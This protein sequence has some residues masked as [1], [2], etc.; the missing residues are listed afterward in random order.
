MKIFS[1]FVFLTMGFLSAQSFAE[2]FEIHKTQIDS[3]VK[4]CPVEPLLIAEE[5]IQAE[6]EGLRWRK[7]KVSCF[8]KLKLRYVHA[9]KVPD[10]HA[11]AGVIKVKRGSLA[12]EA[13]KYNKDFYSY[14]V[15][16]TVED[17]NGMSHKGSFSFMTNAD[18]GGEKPEQGCALISSTPQKAYVYSD[19]LED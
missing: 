4:K 9:L 19:C 12:V 14:E 7:S 13:P 8:E 15:G 2:S 5:I 1:S 18:L 10:A 6:L 16:F 17:I 11:S 3:T